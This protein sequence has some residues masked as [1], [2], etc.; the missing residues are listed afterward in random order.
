MS[1]KKLHKNINIKNIDLSQSK[2]CVVGVVHP[3]YKETFKALKSAI[4]RKKAPDVVLLKNQHLNYLIR[5]LYNPLFIAYAYNGGIGFTKRLI[6]KK[7][8]LLKAIA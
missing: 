8:S 1:Q 2:Y 5:H 3:S 6:T 4:A 7:A